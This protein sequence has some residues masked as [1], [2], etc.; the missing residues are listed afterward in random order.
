MAPTPWQSSQIGFSS[1]CWSAATH[2]PLSRT[3]SAVV[4]L[5]S[6]RETPDLKTSYELGVNAYVVKPVGFKE[7]M[8]AVKEL[9][10]FWALINEFPPR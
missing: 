7:F 9:G 10:V 8:D 6:S 3:L 1:S 4:M 2:Q 5:T